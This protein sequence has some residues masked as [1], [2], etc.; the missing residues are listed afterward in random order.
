MKINRTSITLASAFA[1]A[2]TMPACSTMAQQSSPSPAAT[3]EPRLTVAKGQYLSI[4]MPDAKPDADAARQSYY[5]QALPLGEK[6]GLKREVQLKVDNAVISDYE[7]SGLI[8]FSYPDHAS[9]KQLVKQSEWPAIKAMRPAAWNELR[10]YSAAVEKDMDISF[11]PAKYYTLVVAWTNPEKPED[12]QR[13]LSGIENA[14]SNA[15][16]RFIYKMNNPTMEAHATALESPNQLT[17][18]EWDAPNGFAKVQKTADYKSS[19]PYFQS[20]I[21]NVEF[22]EMSVNGKP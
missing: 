14:V 17:F 5:R 3:E 19:A 6:F 22:Y 10:I 13:Y 7:P 15:G 21:T 12:Y 9:E 4:I 18:V 8:F 2:L 1:V 20:G 11:D 16:G